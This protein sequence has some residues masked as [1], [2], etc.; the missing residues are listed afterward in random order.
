[1]EIAPR[2]SEPPVPFMCEVL[3]QPSDDVS[4]HPGSTDARPRAPSAA[5]FRGWANVSRRD[6]GKVLLR[7]QVAPR[8]AKGVVRGRPTSSRPITCKSS[9]TAVFSALGQV[10]R[11]TKGLERLVTQ[12]V[13]YVG[14]RLRIGRTKGGDVY[15]YKRCAW[16]EEQ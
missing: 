13:T 2:P 11:A 3:V 9:P 12:E 4:R 10:P 1:M 5:F 7:Q 14:S 6:S 15:V 16:P 8:P